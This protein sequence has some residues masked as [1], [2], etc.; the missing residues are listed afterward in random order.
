MTEEITNNTE[1]QQSTPS[2]P[3]VDV[4]KLDKATIKQLRKNIE[5]LKSRSN[6]EELKQV[7]HFDIRTFFPI[8]KK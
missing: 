4:G 1:A 3:G 2:A 6:I 7:P 8:G 5:K